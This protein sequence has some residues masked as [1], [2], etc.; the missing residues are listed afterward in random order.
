MGIQG[1]LPALRAATVATHLRELR[2]QTCAVDVYSWIHR[3]TYAC[4]TELCLE[5]VSNGYITFC[6]VMLDLLL[7]HAITPIMVFDGA[8]LIAKENV[9]RDRESRRAN[10][11]EEGKRLMAIG[12]SKEASNAFSRAVD[13]TPDMAREVVLAFRRRNVQVIVAP[14]EADAQ[15]AFLSLHNKVDFVISEDSDCLPFGCK[16][17][18]FKLD[19]TGGGQM[20]DAR[21]LR[22]AED[23]YLEHFT[24]EMFLDMCILAGCDYL[25]SIQGI[26]MKTAHQLVQKYKST[27]RILRGL[28]FECKQVIPKDYAARFYKAKLTFKHQTVYSPDD[29]KFVYLSRTLLIECPEYPSVL[30]DLSFLGK[31]HPNEIAVAWAAG[32]LNVSTFEPFPVI[33]ECKAPVK[34]EASPATLPKCQTL[35]S[36]FSSSLQKKKKKLDFSDPARPSSSTSS[37]ITVNPWVRS[38]T[39]STSIPP[40]TPLVTTSSAPRSKFFSGTTPNSIPGSLRGPPSSS[41]TPRSGFMPFLSD[42]HKISS[43]RSQQAGGGQDVYLIGQINDTD[44]PELKAANEV[45]ENDQNVEIVVEEE[46]EANSKRVKLELKQS[47]FSQ[48][49]YQQ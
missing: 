40:V 18:L 41:S 1:L 16:R 26:G 20:I 28:R 8:R 39:A 13:V 44:P 27:E 32:D 17:V 38:F 29:Q 2:G 6:M 45:T 5:G 7:A 22:M 33:E 48:F 10:G 36:Y 9:E 46:I 12:K 47:S 34:E 30:E 4:A 23:I 49:M 37:S 19:R 21:R 35:D 42:H 31:P 15:L 24:Q 11:L 25:D 14:F 43:L 3:G